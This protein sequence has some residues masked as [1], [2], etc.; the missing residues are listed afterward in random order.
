MLEAG[1]NAVDAAVAAALTL[2]VVEP[3]LSGIGGGGFMVVQDGPSGMERA[4]DFG[5]CA[6]NR[7]N[8]ADY[9]LED[10]ADDGDWFHWPKVKEGRNIHGYASIG[11]PGAVAGLAE[12]LEKLG[13]LP[14][15]QV[16]EPA[17][18]EARAGLELDWMAALAL[19]MD[20]DM[21]LRYPESA[22]LWLPEGRV[23]RVAAGA[24]PARLPLTAHVAT[25][26]RLQK[27]GPQDFYTGELAHALA[28][29][30]RKGGS[31]LDAEDL[32]AYRPQWKEPLRGSYRGWDV[33]LMPGNSAGPSL[34]RALGSLER[35]LRPSGN[36]PGAEEALL[37]SRVCR[38]EYEYRLVHM[39]H[40]A[41][42][43][44]SPEPSCTSNLCV[45]DRRGTVVALTNTLLSRFGSKVTSPSL[46]MLLNNGMM[47][48]DPL[49]GHPNSM[50]P[51]V[52][53]LSNMCP[54]TVSRADGER[55]A[56]GAAGGRTIFPTLVQILSYVFDF[57][58]SLEEAFLEPRLDAS[59]ETI[60]ISSRADA[61]VPAR[62]AEAFPVEVVDDTIYP[63]RFSLP[64]AVRHDPS[65]GLNT[66]MAH[67]N[68]PWA[69]AV[70]EDVS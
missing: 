49:P 36:R 48:F 41:V 63:T 65:T 28:D 60:R 12:A 7:L 22:A 32:A 62:V 46:G 25:L 14:W 6:S 61:A 64:S 50:A 24:R 33:A 31:P 27:A 52:R 3:W 4:L 5:I 45:V 40:S 38:E 39:G 13:T 30:L 59:T 67:H 44:S 47:W 8:P 66:G 23:S 26:E 20:A 54:L 1:G 18:E 16:I 56:L 2:S 9:P 19:A 69:A 68:S 37:Y 42:P 70:A 55:Y 15:E 58:M 21:L 29:D 51:G 17:I 10:A 43:G 53:P 57:G 34:L 11:V 35:R